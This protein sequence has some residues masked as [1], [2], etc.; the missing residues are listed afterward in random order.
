MLE[1]ALQAKI[2]AALRRLGGWWVKY[3]TEGRYASAGVP[4]II[5]CYRGR[6]IALEVK[7]PG[8]K[9]T[10]LQAAT[11]AA[12]RKEGQGIAEVVTSVDEALSLVLTSERSERD[13]SEE[14]RT[15]ARRRA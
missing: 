8:R 6:F 9:P 13:A 7:R 12:I 4:D 11:I 10:P 15:G 3:H 1:R 5:G 2:L 14:G